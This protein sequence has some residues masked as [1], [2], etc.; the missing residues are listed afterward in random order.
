MLLLK[1]FEP[2]RCVKGNSAELPHCNFAFIK[3]Y[4]TCDQ[5]LKADIV[6]ALI[7]NRVVKASYENCVGREKMC[8]TEII[9]ATVI[10]SNYV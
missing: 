2:I 10:V 4:K 6:K 7:T 5:L 9:E 1:R 3:L 8:C